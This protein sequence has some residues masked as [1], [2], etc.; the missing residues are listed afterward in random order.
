M[1]YVH[2]VS[3]FFATLLSFM[4]LLFFFHQELSPRSPISP[5]IS[6][7]CPPPGRGIVCCF[8][9]SFPRRE[10]RSRIP[11]VIQVRPLVPP[12]YCLWA[13]LL[14]VQDCA[15]N[16]LGPAFDVQAFSVSSIK[17]PSSPECPVDAPTPRPL[18]IFHAGWKVVRGLSESCDTLQ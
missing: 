16:T 5:W 8:V 13:S 3:S 7:L 1:G 9:R 6:P 15:R 17:W 10:S 12:L 2:S 11:K 18:E 4:F 14:P